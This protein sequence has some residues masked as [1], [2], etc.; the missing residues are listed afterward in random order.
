MTQPYPR[1]PITEALIEFRFSGQIADKALSKANQAFKRFYPD[2]QE[3]P[4]FNV[5]VNPGSP[6]L[7]E[8]SVVSNYRRSAG[9][10]HDAVFMTPYSF[11]ALQTFP[12]SGWDDFFKRIERDWSI[13]KKAVGIRQIVRIGMRYINRIDISMEDINP[14]SAIEESDF[15][16]FSVNSPKSLG[17][18]AGYAV[19]AAFIIESIN[20]KVVV[21]S[22]V[23]VPPPVP[24]HT[25]LL[26]DIDIG[27]DYAPPQKDDEI[28]ELLAG[29]RG[30]KNRIFEAIIT[31][32]TREMF[33]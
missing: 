20:A 23:I 28:K 27:R 17:S 6:K 33:Q 30:E 16:N 1:P 9:H 11:A 18:F 7:A 24:M 13:W 22:G 31:N 3:T 12:Y 26:L 29:M 14:D 4:H 32:K 25:S 21:N 10:E 15:L 5:T 19:Q 8:T 2:S